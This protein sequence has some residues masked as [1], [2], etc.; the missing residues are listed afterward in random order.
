M[1]LEN[2]HISKLDIDHFYHLGITSSDAH[3]FNDVKVKMQI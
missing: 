1:N 3:K 2:P